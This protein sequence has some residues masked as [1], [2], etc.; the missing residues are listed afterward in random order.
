MKGPT[1]ISCCSCRYY[2]AAIPHLLSPPW[3]W[4]WRVPGCI[5]IEGV[6][7]EKIWIYLGPVS[8]LQVHSCSPCKLSLECWMPS[9]MT[10]PGMQCFFF[11][12]LSVSSA[13][14]FKSGWPF[15][16]PLPESSFKA[17]L[18]VEGKA[19]LFNIHDVFWQKY[20]TVVSLC[21]NGKC[22]LLQTVFIFSSANR[23]WH[24]S[25]PHATCGWGVLTEVGLVWSAH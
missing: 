20:I 2:Y 12:P 9:I 8:C 7:L 18:G 22:L 3:M 24:L 25:F 5:G 11:P 16:L 14:W 1:D 13:K 4:K 17:C 6:C 10:K 19:F 23:A 21:L 15:I